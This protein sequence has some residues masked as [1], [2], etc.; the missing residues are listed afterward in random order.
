MEKTQRETIAWVDLL[1][2]IACF[3][4]ILAH[5]CDPF[6]GKFDDNPSE[7]LSGALFGSLVT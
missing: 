2:I 3:L 1:R 4:V 5:A 6:V 7:F